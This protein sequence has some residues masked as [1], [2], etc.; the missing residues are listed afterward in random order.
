[1][2]SVWGAT[3]LFPSVLSGTPQQTPIH[4]LKDF[5]D[6][7]VNL[8]GSLH[9]D[10]DEEPRRTGATSRANSVRFDE[11]ANQGHWAHAS[12]SSIDFL[13]RSASSLAGLGMTERTS[14]HKSDGRASSVHS[15]RSAASGRASSINLDTGYASPVDTPAIAPGLLILGPAPAIVRCWVNR[16]FKHDALLYA[17]VSTASYR[18]QIDERLV[19]H[20]GLDDCIVESASGMRSLALS[21]YF[22][23]AIPHPISTRSSSP[24]PQVPSVTVD[25]NIVVSTQPDLDS[26]AIQIVIGSD[27]L[28]SHNADVLFSSNSMTLI[29][30]DQCKLSIPLVRPENEN[31]FNSLF[32]SSL[33]PMKPQEMVPEEQSQLNGLGQTELNT[34]SNELT[35]D[36][37][38]LQP[39]T[40]TIEQPTEKPVPEEDVST[41]SG[42]SPSVK[43]ASSKKQKVAHSAT[44]DPRHAYHHSVHDP[45]RQPSSPQSSS[46]PSSNQAGHTP[47]SPPRYIPPHLHVD[48]RGSSPSDA[49]AQLNLAE[50]MSH[51]TNQGDADAPL[52]TQRPASPAKRSAATM[53]GIDNNTLNAPSDAP[54]S[55]D[56][57]QQDASSSVTPSIDEQ[58]AHIQSLL[59]T[60]LEDG[61]KGYIVA[62]K[63]FNRVVARTEGAN[64]KDFDAEMLQGEIGK[65]DN[66]SVVPLGAFENPLA[67][68]AKPD[69]HFIPLRA[70]V[71]RPV[72]YEI[73]TE[74][75]WRQVVAWYGIMEGQKPIIRFAHNSAPQESAS[76]HIV[77]ETSPP[78]FTVRK[79]PS[80][81]QT[82]QLDAAAVKVVASR[83]ERFQS[84]LARA[85]EA[86]G[87]PLQ[88][89]VKIFRQLDPTKVS[90]DIPD[91]AQQGIPSPPTSRN[92][93]PSP[94]TSKLVIETSAFAKWTEG[95]NFESVDGQDH[96]AN[97]KYN[98]SLNL[99]ILGLTS[100][101]V[102][103]LEEQQ[104]GAEFASDVAKKG[105]KNNSQLSQTENASKRTITA[106]VTRGRARKDGR[107]RGTI[108]LINLG[109]TCYMNSALQCISRVEELAV[110]FLHQKHK[111]EI[112][113]DN[114]LGYNGRIANAYANFLAGLYS[115]NATSAYRPNGFKGA[116]SMAQPMFSGYGQQDSQEFLSFLVDALHE[117]LNRI[118]KKPYIE[119]PDSDDKTVHDPEAI[120]QLG[121]TYRANHHA[122]N[123]SI[124]MDLFNGFYKNTMVC[125]E[126]DKVSVTFDPYSLLTL[127]LP[128][129]N[130]WQAKIMFM[131]VT[132]YPSAF[133][134]DVEKN[135]S[136]RALKDIFVGKIGRGLNR[137]RLI[138]AEIFSHRFY[139]IGYDSQT[140]SELDFSNNDVL[141]MYEVPEAPTNAAFMPK[142][143]ATYRSY[144][145]DSPVESLPGMDSPLAETM[146]IPVFHTKTDK[147]SSSPVLNPTLVTITREEAK[148]YDA[149]LRKVLTSVATMTTKRILDNVP[150]RQDHDSITED[151]QP[152]TDVSMRDGSQTPSTQLSETLPS[153]NDPRN[154]FEL[155]YV[156]ATGDMFMTGT[157]AIGNGHAMQTRVRNVER[158]RGSTSSVT[159]NTSGRSKDS[160]Y[161]GQGRS[162]SDD[163]QDADPMVE[164]FKANGQNDF[165]GDVQSD[166][167]SGMGSLEQ[168]SA[169]DNRSRKFN[170]KKTYSRK[171]GRPH[172]KN[173]ARSNLLRST[174]ADE[175]TDDNEFYVKLGE[176]IVIEWQAD[177]FESMF[178]GGNGNGQFTFNEK[179]VPLVD[180][181]ELQVR[182]NKRMQR[183]KNGITLEDCFTETGK[184]EVLSE[185][186][187]WYCGRCKE[188]RRASKTLELWT[189][190]DIL[191]VHLKRFSGERFRRDKVDVLVDFPIEG[192]DL[193]QRV[194]CKEEGKEYIYDLFAVDNH[195]GGLGGGH[196]TAYAKNFYDGNWYDYNDSSVS[197]QNA[198]S[199][200]STA[201][202][203]LFY[204]RRSTTP[205]GPPYLQELVLKARNPDEASEAEDESG[206]GERLG[207]HSSAT[208]RL[209]GSS[210]AGAVGAGATI[211]GT[212][213]RGANVDGPGRGASQAVKSMNETD[214]DEGISLNDELYGNN[215]NTTAVALANPE[216]TWSFAGL[217]ED[218][219]TTSVNTPAD[220]ASDRPDV[221]SDIEDR[222]MD[223]DRDESLPPLVDDE[224][225][226]TEGPEQFG[227][228]SN[229]NQ[230]E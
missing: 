161:D 77:Y 199:V 227:E 212:L 114:P 163:D 147:R 100:N 157:N 103:I 99:E 148:D 145:H 118:H 121:D 25:F 12:R 52:P 196:Y 205:L 131:P 78:V 130:T 117:D 93:S 166:D 165:A 30:D 74:E 60:P 209:L 14:S 79:V 187:A 51:S 201:A 102:L 81:Q 1:M 175:P 178:G 197:R 58:V 72:D 4:H 49:Y 32:I 134:I 87:I 9:L 128:I 226:A 149:I 192:L 3:S 59:N 135:I 35:F 83:T 146:A 63:W 218:D 91:I 136:V 113:A 124:A 67:F 150:N 158:R 48:S 142:K 37:E 96:T 20:L 10:P 75:A 171:G 94:S 210:D 143:Q 28:R 182:R 186:N 223:L 183:K 36:D 225:M 153:V 89:K 185:D 214:D 65:I 34:P 164:S 42:G 22:A 191:V 162:S 92:P 219:N 88:H 73:F 80:T 5:D 220:T 6:E 17:A 109:N 13:P 70:D 177:A 216:A 230:D 144:Y 119:N 21:V 66:S 24:A 15:V 194:G 133:E 132:G 56:A 229:A 184:T 68:P 125:P 98:G 64:K 167:E 38:P 61:S 160:G 11:S 41:D 27:V 55:Y 62:S 90:G 207:D 44:D 195:Y 193:T 7:P 173:R 110:Y 202:Y 2:K 23:E 101:Q 170:K 112:N 76:V 116:L 137:E 217:G 126:C 154:M 53:E 181:T 31:T 105:K 221:G 129:E 180:D 86:A 8:I 224:T 29:D 179:D 156:Q 200:V 188:L 26:K 228:E 82:A 111:P 106:P 176:G 206:E 127:Q 85:K 47:S 123:D 155:K 54:P 43:T 107:T 120:R 151:A 33:Q 172:K 152:D 215:T 95:T 168:L 39:V 19:Q 211:T 104:R 222:L 204:R 139:K 159:S 45:D 213:H 203:L 18:S 50:D 115:D 140:L 40:N 46:S 69:Q 174:A 208:S 108:G 16:N 122:R 138:F 169:K 71:E 97:E 189:V 84:F 57:Y 141:C 198:E 190:P